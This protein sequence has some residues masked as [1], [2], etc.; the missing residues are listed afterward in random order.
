MGAQHGRSRSHGDPRVGMFAPSSETGGGPAVREVFCDVVVS[1]LELSTSGHCA[2]P[3]GT[4][5][6]HSAHGARERV[7]THMTF[8]S[9]RRL[10]GLARRNRHVWSI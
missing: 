7:L 5:S 10:R 9:N 4:C 2:H 1:D 8:R 3:P 6:A